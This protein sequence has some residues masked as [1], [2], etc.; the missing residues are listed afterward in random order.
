MGRKVPNRK[1]GNVALK[2]VVLAAAA[3]T[4]GANALSSVAAAEDNQ[5][6]QGD[7]S[8]GRN[9]AGFGGGPHCH[10]LA[11][12]QADGNFTYVRVYPSHTGHLSS[13]GSAVAPLIADAD[14]DGMP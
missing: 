4:V 14:C 1:W 9:D 10:L 11:V 13:N 7:S 2:H 12:E 6:S 5:P 8:T 3:L